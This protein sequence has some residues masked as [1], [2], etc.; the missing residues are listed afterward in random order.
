VAGQSVSPAQRVGQPVPAGHLPDEVG[1]VGAGHPGGGD[2]QR[3]GRGSAQHR[4]GVGGGAERRLGHADHRDAELLAGPGAQA[5]PAAGIQVGVAVDDQ[6][7]Q[8]AHAF[9]GR[10][11]RRELAQVELAR[12]VGRDVRHYGDARASQAGE[13]R[14][15]GHDG[16]RPGTASGQVIHVRRHEYGAAGM[17]ASFHASRMP[18][19]TRSRSVCRAGRPF[20]AE[21]PS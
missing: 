17:L 1:G 16:S 3:P 13:G 19:P 15:G 6:Q 9:Q 5:G 21:C 14:I 11:Q 7:A 10:A 2:V 18:G 20:L 12:L 8:A 4:D